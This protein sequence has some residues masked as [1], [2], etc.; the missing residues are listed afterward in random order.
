MLAG[1]VQIPSPSRESHT[2]LLEATYSVCALIVFGASHTHLHTKYHY[3]YTNLVFTVDISR[4]SSIAMA[5]NNQKR[6]NTADASKSPRKFQKSV[7]TKV[8]SS[9]ERKK[10]RAHKIFLVTPAHGDVW[11][12]YCEYPTDPSKEGFLWGN[13]ERYII[14][15]KD[16]ES[17]NETEK[18]ANKTRMRIDMV[19]SRA[20]PT[21]NIPMKSEPGGQYDWTVFLRIPRDEDNDPEV[22][23]RDIA[24]EFTRVGTDPRV[25]RW[26]TIFEYAGNVTPEQDTDNPVPLT[27]YLM[28]NDVVDVIGCT[29]S[30]LKLEEIAGDPEV[31]ASYFG[32]DN[33]DYGIELLR[34]S[35]AINNARDA[36]ECL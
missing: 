23:V 5:R 35:Q 21:Q 18:M 6:A 24:R 19:L 31:V 29:Y 11:L 28:E 26:T 10:H 2:N 33:V 7:N 25:Y 12:A 4:L 14:T 16:K 32:R 27:R 15:K 1:Q 13:K 3:A 17:G 22:W 9:S 36:A 34:N 8:A 30:N 20:H